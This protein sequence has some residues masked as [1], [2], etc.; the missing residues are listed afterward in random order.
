MI[1]GSA[2]PIVAHSVCY[3]SATTIVDVDIDIDVDKGPAM[4]P[5]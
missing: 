3:I 5:A 2:V 4:I 1:I